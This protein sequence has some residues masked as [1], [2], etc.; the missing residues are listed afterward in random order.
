VRGWLSAGIGLMA[1]ASNLTPTLAADLIR[2]RALPPALLPANPTWSGWYV[3]G[4]VGYGWG[5]STDPSISF[6]DPGGPVAG[7][8]AFFNAGGNLFPSHNPSG[9]LGGLQLGYNYQTGP[10]VW[11]VVTDFQGSDIKASGTV[12]T[13]VPPTLGGLD[14]SLSAK[15]NWFGTVRGKVGWAPAPDWLLYGTGGLAYGQ[16]ES[17]LGFACTP[18]AGVTCANVLVSG[19]QKTTKVGWTAGAG[20]DYAVTSA[21][22]VGLEYLYLDLGRD[23]VTGVQADLPALTVSADQHFAAHVLRGTLN[24][25]FGR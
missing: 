22:T 1:L 15:I 18:P 19:S 8:S 11:G 24:W 3:G 17:T 21:L 23:T 14:E 25:R 16:V 20:V 4:N 9:V 13:P 5:A 12:S 7:I 2:A 10:W 6:T